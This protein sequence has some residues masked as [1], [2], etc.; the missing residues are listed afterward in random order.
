M[1]ILIDTHILIWFLEGN[2]LLSSQRQKILSD[3]QN[4]VLSVLQVFWEMAIKISLGKLT[5]SKSLS[6]IIKQLSVENIE[7]FPIL[8]N[9]TLQF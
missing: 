1:Q 8:P 7:I 5:L 2:N 3:P 9:H 6:D 4:E